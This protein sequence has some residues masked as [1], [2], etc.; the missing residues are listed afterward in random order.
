MQQL[1]AVTD[2]LDPVL[3]LEGTANVTLDG[4]AADAYVVTTDGQNSDSVTSQKKQ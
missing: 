3:E 1:L 4:K 2:T